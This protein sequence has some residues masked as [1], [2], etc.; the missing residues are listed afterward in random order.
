MPKYSFLPPKKSHRPLSDRQLNHLKQHYMTMESI[1][2]I[3]DPILA[4][5]DRNVEIWYRCCADNVVYHC[6]QYQRVNSSRINHLVYLEQTEDANR[7]FSHRVRPERPV[8]VN[9]YAYVQFYALHDFHGEKQMLMYVTYLQVNIHHG[10]VEYERDR[11]DAFVDVTALRHLC[12]KVT[13]NVGGDRQR[14]Y[15]VDDQETM[16]KRLIDALPRR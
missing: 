5:M 1:A 4:N 15:F 16:E 10:L 7:N 11:R 6:A 13:T 2:H 8:T 12:A 14:V 9:D 3:N